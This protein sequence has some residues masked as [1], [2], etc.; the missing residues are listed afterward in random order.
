M[1]PSSCCSS[2]CH[3]QTLDSVFTSE[4]ISKT[5][6]KCC[7]FSSCYRLMM[8]K[9]IWIILKCNGVHILRYRK[10]LFLSGLSGLSLFFLIHYK[11]RKGEISCFRA[12][13]SPFKGILTIVYFTAVSEISILFRLLITKFLV[14]IP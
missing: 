13:S 14:K 4:E 6:T 9:H 2:S 1:E 3:S 12:N 5:A 8:V 11:C 10:L 7:S